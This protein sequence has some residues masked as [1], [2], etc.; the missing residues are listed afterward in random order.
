MRHGS[1]FFAAQSALNMMDEL[2][3][4]LPPQFHFPPRADVPGR[5][6]ELRESGSAPLR[7]AAFVPRTQ[8]D[9]RNT[10]AHCDMAFRYVRDDR[11]RARP[12]TPAHWRFDDLAASPG[13]GA[14]G[15]DDA[16]TA[17]AS[18][19]KLRRRF[20]M[21]RERDTPPPRK[22]PVV[23]APKREAELIAEDEQIFDDIKRQ[24]GYEFE[25]IIEYPLPGKGNPLFGP[26]K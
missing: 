10:V 18:R 12:P 19:A 6:I 15:S 14:H 17:L 25:Q 1:C 11:I 8:K 24:F 21:R 9:V 23:E 4:H 5:E 2:A 26:V 3:A 22:S 7:N 16:W 20:A 13:G